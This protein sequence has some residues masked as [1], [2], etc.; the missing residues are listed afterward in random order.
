M[1]KT[2]DFQRS[3]H[4]VFNLHVHLVFATKYRRKVLGSAILDDLRNIFSKICS[5]CEAELV[6]FDGEEGHMHLLVHYPP[7]VA[8]SG[9]VNR[10]KGSSSRLIRSRN[11]PSIR[12]K[13]WGTS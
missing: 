3:R 12:R 11:Y 6:E 13:L 8:V 9:L 10:L 7:K 1:G 2:T 5:D 4:A